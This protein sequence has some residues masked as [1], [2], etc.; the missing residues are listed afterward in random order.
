MRSLDVEEWMGRG[1]EEVMRRLLRSRELEKGFQEAKGGEGGG[2]KGDKKQE[3]TLKRGLEE[4]R[5]ELREQ[6]EKWSLRRR[7]RN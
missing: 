7:R 6:K 1:L 4:M 2:E 5:R 3:E